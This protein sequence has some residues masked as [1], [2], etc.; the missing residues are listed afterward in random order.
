DLDDRKDS[1]RGRAKRV[2]WRAVLGTKKVV[3][4]AQQTG[5]PDLR[6]AKRLVQ[7]VVDSIMH[8]E[9]SVVGL[10]ALRDH[11]EYTY[12]HCVNV[13][14][15]SIGMGQALGL[16]R[17]VLADLGVTGL[18]HD[19]GKIAV[20]GEVLRK[21]GKL[22]SQEWDMVRRH[23][24]EGVKMIC[25]LPGLT[26]LTLDAM[27]VCLEHHMNYDRTGY[28]DVELEWGQATLSRIVAVADCFD[29]ITAHRAYHSR[30]RTPFEALQ[31]MLGPSRVTFDPAVLWALVKTVGLYP[32]GSV[33]VTDSGQVAM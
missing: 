32:A 1:E 24:L 4:R 18:L 20:P 15:L 9:Y 21:P 8:H 33:M 28:P 17:Q 30:P 25:R 14:V 26:S 19:I 16:S 11:D 22:D 6:Q 13:S 5:R 29:A 12:A 2:F 10:T 3:L 23:P 27:R 31:Y 7:P